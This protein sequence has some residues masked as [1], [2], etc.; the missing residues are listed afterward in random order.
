MHYGVF[1]WRIMV[2]NGKAVAISFREFFIDDY[3]SDCYSYV[4]VSKKVYSAIFVCASQ[5]KRVAASD[6]LTW[7]EVKLNSY[8]IL[9]MKCSKCTPLTMSD[10]AKLTEFWYGKN[11]TVCIYMVYMNSTSDSQNMYFFFKFWCG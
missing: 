2:D 8:K 3:F 1:Y 7:W 6:W 10:M 9:V 4:A 11:L 5:I